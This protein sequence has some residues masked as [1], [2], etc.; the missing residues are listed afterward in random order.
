MQTPG[1]PT[2]LPDDVTALKAMVL[3]QQGV[4]AARDAQL[5]AQSLH[6]EKLKAQLEGLRR[7]RFG[8]KSESLDQLEL[9]IEDLEA[10]HA[11]SITA[12]PAPEDIAEPRDQAK[13]KPLPDHLPREEIVHVPETDCSYCGK[14]MRKMGEDVREVLD[15]IPGRFVV[16]SHVRP[17]MSCRDC[18]TIAQAP[19]PSLPIEK[20]KPGPGLLAHVLVSK[21]ADHLPLYRQAQ[22]Y[23]REGV[24]ID[25]STMADWLGKSSALL[26]PLVEAIGDHVFAGAAIHT[27]D[28]TVPV[29]DP[30]RGKTKTGRMW[31]YVRD[32]KP[33]GSKKP[34]AAYYRY[35]PD[36]KGEH[37]RQHLENFK[38]F[39]HADG[40]SGYKKLFER[41][42]VTEV[43][44]LAHIRRKFFDIHKATAS[45]VAEEALTRI[46]ALYAI[47]KQVRGLPPDT[48]K[49]VRQDRSKPL[50]EDLQSWLDAT[51]PSLPGRGELA[52][53][54][55]YAITRLKK[56]G[57]WLD[58]GRLEIDNN[59]AERA[60]R[61]L[62]LGRKNWLF[63]GSDT[64]GIRAASLI[65]LIE[66]AK[67]NK[68]DPQAWLTH[69]LATIADHPINKID[70][71]LP[72][73]F[74]TD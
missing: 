4:L 51:L 57:V 5:Y 39:V 45:P 42:G 21:F 67:I 11:Q 9:M 64:G 34:P 20:G 74:K 1:S 26:N 50:F 55:R 49:A 73:N 31:A 65:T 54:I 70:E 17:K 7:H 40:Y 28:T 18:G 23:E 38:G 61:P 48:R 41:D 36:R 27:D 37:P 19:M 3:E 15:Y 66:T 58:D 52:K 22:I 10:A 44:C 46:A 8:A 14:P 6:I 25:T 35:T 29:L 33:Q 12:S 62:A 13:R 60:M 53:A 30:G 69:V 43:A 24:E 72:W 59:A 63:A 2:P 47:E 56:L 32:E 71:L 16:Q 68:V